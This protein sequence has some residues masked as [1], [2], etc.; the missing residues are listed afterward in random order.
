[1]LPYLK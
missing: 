1:M